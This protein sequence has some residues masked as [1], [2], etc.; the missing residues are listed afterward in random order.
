MSIAALAPSERTEAIVVSSSC[1]PPLLVAPAGISLARAPTRDFGSMSEISTFSE[2]NRTPQLMSKPTPPGE[3]APPNS[4][5]LTSV[6]T[7]PP[8]GKP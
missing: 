3:I 6:A 1:T 7:T 8:I 5:A 2:H 4:P